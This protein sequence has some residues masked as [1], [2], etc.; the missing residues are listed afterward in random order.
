LI[1]GKS[2]GDDLTVLCEHFTHHPFIS[3]PR[4]IANE[5]GAAFRASLV[6]K[7]GSTRS[8]AILEISLTL[9][10]RL[11]EVDV[12]WAPVKLSAFLSFVSLGSVFR[13]SELDVAKSIIL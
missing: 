9:G 11:R 12:Q 6:A 4:N 8:G 10:A 5:E 7:I 2:N 1:G 3:V 13:V